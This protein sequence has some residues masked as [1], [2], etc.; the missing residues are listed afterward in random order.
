MFVSLHPVCF[1][2]PVTL[3]SK[4]RLTS[5]LPVPEAAKKP[6]DL[7]YFV[8]MSWL[9]KRRP[10][11][12]SVALVLMA[13]LLVSGLTS[14]RGLSQHSPEIPPYKRGKE[15]EAFRELPGRVLQ[16]LNDNPLA[17]RAAPFVKGE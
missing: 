10:H 11:P 16:S 6:D 14:R 3:S 2:E 15:G 1:C 7:C 12:C 8:T 9:A 17:L 5:N 13:S 4:S